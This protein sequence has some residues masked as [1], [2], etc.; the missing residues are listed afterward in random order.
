MALKIDGEIVEEEIRKVFV[1]GSPRSGTTL[2]QNILSNHPDI[3]TFPELNFFPNLKNLIY[4]FHKLEISNP[5]KIKRRFCEINNLLEPS[6]EWELPSSYE[7]RYKKWIEN[8]YKNLDRL[9]INQNKSIWLEKTPLNLHFM[10][11]I[12]KHSKSPRFIHIMRPGKHV[13]SSVYYYSNKYSE[14]W[15]NRTLDDCIARWKFD[16]K[17]SRLFLREK[18]HSHILYD[19]LASSKRE[20]VLRALFEKIN[21]PFDEKVLQENFKESFNKTVL[22]HE[23]WKSGIKNRILN[24]NGKLW[25]TALNEE[26]RDYVEKSIKNISL[27]EFSIHQ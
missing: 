21:I 8:L 23:K 4:L 11:K 20:L 7:F 16:I 1:V 15:G 14:I 10:D 18:L 9:A 3:L 22:S 2:L 5:K 6:K 19:E 25:L 12:Q 27:D 17:L 13:I 26:Q 24:T